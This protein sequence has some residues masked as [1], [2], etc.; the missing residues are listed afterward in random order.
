MGN[1][2]L[3]GYIV[4]KRVWSLDGYL[5]FAGNVRKRMKH[6]IAYRFRNAAGIPG[7][8]AVARVKMKVVVEAF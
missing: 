6:G 7:A 4:P 1:K 8:A 2:P 5:L 3:A